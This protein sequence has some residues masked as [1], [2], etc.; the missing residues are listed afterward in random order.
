MEPTTGESSTAQN[1]T[2][3]NAPVVVGNITGDR[4]IMDGARGV[5]VSPYGLYVYVTGSLSDGV[6]VAI[7]VVLR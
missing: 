3:L 2:S 4:T 1:C 5:A 6:A 7:L